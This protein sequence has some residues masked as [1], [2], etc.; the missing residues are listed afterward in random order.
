M[1]PSLA[2]RLAGGALALFAAAA[3]APPA[4]AER[5]ET[6]AG[7]FEEPVRAIE[8]EGDALVIRT[9]RAAIP[10]AEVKEVRF[11][12]ADGEPRP[13]PARLFLVGGDMLTGEVAGGDGEKVAFEAPSIGRVEV[14][15]DA[16]AAVVWSEDEA[17][18]RAFRARFLDAEVKADVLVTRQGGR[19][20]GV[21]ERIDQR[22]CTIESKGIGKLTLGPEKALGVRVAPLGKP[23]ARPK[24]LYA[25]VELA[26]GSWI[27]ATVE[28]LRDGILRLESPLRKPLE[29]RIPEV[30]SI[31][32]LG[33]RF[34][35]VSDLEPVEVR[36][37]TDV[38]G[39][40]EKKPPFPYFRRDRSVADAPIRL[41]GRTYRKGLGVHAYTRAVYDL[42]GAYARFV[43]RVG[44][45]DSARE[46]RALDGTVKF[47]VFV[48][49]KPALGEGI[50][51][52]TRDGSRPIEV[53][54]AGAR[55]LELVADFGESRDILARGNWADAYL[56]RK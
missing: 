23:P 36:S 42:G 53:D 22:G 4:R 30:R 2:G 34:T 1:L 41:D 20:E 38:I 21:I 43:A 33:G 7:D 29:V 40:D 28:S 13:G 9:P 46:R 17:E 12:A 6:I 56:V 32:F 48:D 37:R 27:T 52:T 45:D 14:P 44:L 5:I 31:A 54:V 55:R 39:D 51:L 8:R 19:T 16:V 26:D 10:C 15:L 11:A 50:T 25:R 24:G 3:I 49:G 47:Q 35:Y 18:I